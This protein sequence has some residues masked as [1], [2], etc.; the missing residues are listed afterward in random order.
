MSDSRTV[1]DPATRPAATGASPD[2]PLAQAAEVGI[3]PRP[4]DRLCEW[5]R[6]QN[7]DIRSF[8]IV[9]DGRLVFEL[10]GDGL[11]RASNHETYSIT[12]TVTSLL[13]GILADEGRI[14]P[15]DK[16]ADWL[17]R[18]HPDLTP[19]L[20]DKQAIELGHLL[21]MSSGL[22]YTLTGPADPLANPPNRLQIALTAAAKAAPAT[23]FNYTIVSPDARRAAITAASGVPI[24]QFAEERLL[25]PL[26][27]ENYGWTG[28]DQTGVV[29]GGSGLRLRAMDIAKLGVMM[30]HGGRWQGEQIVPQ[31]WIREMSTPKATARDYGYF[32][33]INH[34]VET[35]PA[36]GAMGFRG[37]FMTILPK[38]N[39]VIVMT[40]LLPETG[41]VKDAAFLQLYRRMVND[42]VLPALQGATAASFTGSAQQALRQEPERGA[43][44][45]GQSHPPVAHPP[46][47]HP[48]VAHPPVAHPPV[49]HPP[50]AHP[51][52]AHPPS[53]HAPAA[54]HTGRHAP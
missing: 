50:V 48:P 26:Q 24:D 51:P 8:L 20:Q 34:V 42:Y 12:N 15:T 54:Q 43:E 22:F 21:S 16:L 18:D 17:A 23:V 31:A 32:C 28:A 14:S 25:K 36:F 1:D 41:G 45:A 35:E 19:A 30:L 53:A 3:D 6:D 39:A 27:M 9:K 38:R 37:Q 40:S 52:L 46:V 44:P 49:A 13:F 47:A 2:L 7:L 5:I 33:W 10:Y 11:E 29:S 4:L